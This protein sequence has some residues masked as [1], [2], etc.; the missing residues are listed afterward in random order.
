MMSAD[1]ATP[2]PAPQRPS[3]WPRL[4][5]GLV[6]GQ[7]LA[8]ASTSISLMPPWSLAPAT[9]WLYPLALALMLAGPRWLRAVAWTWVGLVASL[10]AVICWT[11]LSARLL[12]GLTVD[13]GAAACDAIVVLSASTTPTTL[14]PHSL[15]RML[16]GVELLQAGLAP[17]IVFTGE[18]SCELNRFTELAPRTMAK[19]GLATDR[20]VTFEAR[21]GLHPL[22]THGE[23]LSVADMV[24]RHGWR[25]VLVVTSASHTLRTKLTF[26]RAGVPARVVPCPSV[27]AAAGVGTRGRRLRAFASIPYEYAALVMYR[28]HGWL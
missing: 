3:V 25:S 2:T 15:D 12:A 8:I 28:L 24:R 17:V 21:S 7:L 19:L 22:N 13:D 23:A 1:A 16:Y 11:P 5:L 9:W 10:T 18:P 27:A 14:S 26:R 20:V 6:V 4:L